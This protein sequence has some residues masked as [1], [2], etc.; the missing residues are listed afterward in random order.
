MKNKIITKIIAYALIISE[1]LFCLFSDSFSLVARADGNDEEIVEEDTT[2]D[3]VIED[4]VTSEYEFVEGRY[5]R[6]DGQVYMKV[7][8]VDKKGA[9][10]SFYDT[11]IDVVWWTDYQPVEE[12]RV[13]EE[14]LNLAK[15]KKANQLKDYKKN[16]LTLGKGKK[17]DSLNVYISEDN[18]KIHIDDTRK[19]KKINPEKDDERDFTGDYVWQPYVS[20]HTSIFEDIL[21]F[22]EDIW[23]IDTVPGEPEQRIERGTDWRLKYREEEVTETREWTVKEPDKYVHQK[24]KW[25][26]KKYGI[27]L[28][29]ISKKML[30]HFTGYAMVTDVDIVSDA[31]FRDYHL[32]RRLPSAD[33]QFCADKADE[34]AVIKA[35]KAL[36]ESTVGEALLP[37]ELLFYQDIEQRKHFSGIY[38]ENGLEV[39]TEVPLSQ[40]DLTIF[41]GLANIDWMDNNS[42]TEVGY[43]VD[44]KAG[45]I[46]LL[47]MADN[48]I[49]NTGGICERVQYDI[50]LYFNDDGS[51]E[52]FGDILCY[53]QGSEVVTYTIFGNAD[54]FLIDT[55]L[56]CNWF[57]TETKGEIDIEVVIPGEEITYKE[58]EK[59]TKRVY[60]WEEENW[61]RIIEIPGMP[62]DEVRKITIIWE[63][64]AWYEEHHIHVGNWP[65]MGYKPPEEDNPDDIIP[66]DD[67]DTGDNNISADPDNP[68]DE[69]NQDDGKNPD[70]NNADKNEPEE[71]DADGKE[72]TVSGN[73]NGLPEE[74]S[75]KERLSEYTP[76][77][78]SS[79]IAKI[80]A[81]SS[82]WNQSASNLI[83]GKLNTCWSEG[84]SGTGVGEEII[85]VFDGEKTLGGM[86][87]A[88]GC[89][90]S[91][92]AYKESGIATKIKLTFSDGKSEYFELSTDELDVENLQMSDYLVF[93][94]SHNSN[95]VRIT[96]EDAK[97]G[98]KY[99][100]TCISELYFD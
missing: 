51:V 79:N 78:S 46:R 15:V 95:Y 62:H 26:E 92:K 98:S 59:Y 56:E 66:I 94:E 35:R 3:S 17:D 89:F 10:V 64:Y 5:I 93:S 88:N 90:A 54:E 58:T 16:I 45:T 13:F 32:N 25:D 20:G 77:Y 27:S 8:Y 4:E 97:A 67:N 53:G 55:E 86:G 83:D 44:E 31:D 71:N 11:D 2:N 57:F 82:L 22:E 6:E 50:T 19:D 42:N 49:T 91:N 38:V 80:A 74:F 7:Y 76:T 39:S 29:E 34:D 63:L 65:T 70:D 28:E 14:R 69:T 85:V 41:Y 12:Q 47:A 61:E 84:V 18:T 37:C 24:I 100:D 81:S 23:I 96:I 1:L 43:I 68:I 60:Y 72:E 33:G 30:T 48:V 73:K 87:I 52:A 9:T 99:E 40:G 21:K 36:L 75:Q